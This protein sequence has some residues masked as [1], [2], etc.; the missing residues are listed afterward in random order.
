MNPAE[1]ANIARAEQEM[2]WFRGMRSILKA[3]WARAGKPQFANVLEAGC[4]TGFMSRWMAAEFGWRMTP[5]DLDFV[6]L[7]HSSLPRRVQGDITRLPFRDASFDALVSLDVVVHLPRGEEAGAFAEFARVVKPGGALIL[8]AS[9]LDVL[10]SRHSQFAHERQRFTASR[11]RQ[12]IEAA[13]FATERLTYANSLLLPVAFAKFRLWEPLTKAPVSS[14][15]E[16][17]AAWLNRLLE[18]PLA[19]EAKWIAA[20]GSFPLGQSLLVWARRK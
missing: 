6:G 1:F 8:R 2:W 14:G 4:G 19:A 9:A 13:G 11:L 10:R 18:V 7:S 3:W 16:I 5:L 20:G 17:P 12:G 15:V